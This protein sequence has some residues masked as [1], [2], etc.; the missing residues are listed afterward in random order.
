MH[1]EAI[2]S[3]VWT[4]NAKLIGC[5]YL[6]WSIA[7]GVSGL[8]MSWIMRAELCGLSEQVLFGDHQLY[9]V[10]TT[11][12]GILML[13]YFIMPG[14]MSGLGNLLVPIQLGVPELMFPKVNN[15]GTWLLVDGYL[16]LVGSSWV[17]EGAGTAWTVY[18]PLSMTASH[19][20]V[21]VDTFIVSLHAAGLSSLTGAINLMVTCCYARRTHSCVLQ[22]S[23][24]PW[25]VAITGALLVGIIP[26]LAGAI[27]MLLT[28]RNTGTV[29]YDVVAGGDPVMYEHLFWVFGHPE[30][31]VI[32]LPVFGLVS[33]SLHRGGLFS[34][35]NM[36]GMVYAMIAIAVVGYF[37]WA[38]HMFTVGLDVDTR[39]YFSSATLLI[40]LPTSI[41]VFSWMVGL[42]RMALASSA[43]WYVV[44]FLLMFLL[45]GVTGLVLA[46]SEV[47]LVMH[48][49]YYV[50]AHF[51]YVLSLGAVFGLLNGVLSCHELCSGYRS[52]AWLLRV[53]V[54]LLVWGTTC[55]FWGMHLSGTLGLSRRVPD[56]PDGYLGTVVSTTC[57]ILV[58]LLVVALLLCASLEASLWD[59]Q[60][61]RATT[62][63]TNPG[64]HNHMLSGMHSLDHA[65]RGQLML[66]TCVSTSHRA[67]M[68]LEE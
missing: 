36:L 45:G 62:R 40:A 16:L 6:S 19:G 23:L 63:S 52:A 22:S 24:Y 59:T 54:V 2:A 53:Q 10:L 32:I 49:S 67:S 51:H 21:S 35:Y 44:A 65:T 18:P 26:V 7:F 20:G 56:A 38:H 5:V 50:V 9:N 46:N 55:I 28:D 3:V 31:Y 64:M 17:D 43:A 58:V 14:V 8:L 29:F 4:T 48:D 15:V 25:S 27:T 12:H 39:V 60:Q 47:D 68:H 41:K 33:H 61:L 13:F 57:G 34:L 11:T 42:R 1:L 66:H 30:V 37:V